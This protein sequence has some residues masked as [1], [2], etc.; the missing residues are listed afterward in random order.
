MVRIV[1]NN[2]WQYNVFL[3]SGLGQALQVKTNFS[4][5]AT[6]KQEN[7]GQIVAAETTG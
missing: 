5:T 2:Y 1:G 4:S 6:T 7:N 3:T